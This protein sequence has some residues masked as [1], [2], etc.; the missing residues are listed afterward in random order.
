[1]GGS[2]FSYLDMRKYEYYENMQTKYFDPDMPTNYSTFNSIA[3]EGFK[4]HKIHRIFRFPKLARTCYGLQKKQQPN[5]QPTNPT[6][7]QTIRM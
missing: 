1:M 6:N 5:N 3:L 2:L 4:L 7:K